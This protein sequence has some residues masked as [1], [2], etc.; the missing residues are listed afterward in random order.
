MYSKQRSTKQTAQPYNILP[1]RTADRIPKTFYYYKG[2]V[3]W[4]DGKKLRNLEKIR[5]SKK[6]YRAANKEKIRES[7]KK[8][9]AANKE[10]IRERDKKYRAA[11][12]EKIRERDKKYSKEYYKANKEK[13]RERDKKYYKANKEK[14]RERE[15][16]YRA[17]NKEKISERKKEYRAR[18]ENKKRRNKKQRNRYKS[19]EK[20]KLTKLLRRRFLRALKSQNTKKN[21]HVLQ[22][23]SCTM[24]FLRD[25]LSQQFE[26]GM[27]WDNQGDWHI[28]H[29]KPCRSFDLTKEEEQRKCFHYT[30][31]QPLWGSENIRKSDTFNEATFEYTWVEHKGWEKK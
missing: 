23:T 12:K 16:E 3:R 27:T 26:K 28:D 10:K 1:K 7:K 9:R 17:A 11:N 8:Y 31:L 20:Y 15:K 22:L 25:Y 4:W 5:E 29:R 2:E 18:A 21:T 30:N 19:D 14:I 6:K 24:D 13:I